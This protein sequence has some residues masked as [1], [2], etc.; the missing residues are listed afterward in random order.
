MGNPELPKLMIQELT[1]LQTIRHQNIMQVK[2]ILATPTHYYVAA[3]IC[4]GGEL[5]DRILEV[6][7]FGEFNAADII[8]QMISAINFMHT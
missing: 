4:H 3:E 5:F 2:E 6:K 8:Q 1:I 7:K